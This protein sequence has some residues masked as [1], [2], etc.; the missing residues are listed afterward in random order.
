[1]K[2]MPDDGQVVMIQGYEF[3]ATEVRIIQ[4][5]GQEVLRFKGTC[6]DNPCNDTI[7]HTGFNGGTY[8]HIVGYRTYD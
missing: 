3:T 7:R 5:H 2:D 4:D 1:M 8:G 6:T